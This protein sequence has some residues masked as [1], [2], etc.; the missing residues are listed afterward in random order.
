MN[1]HIYREGVWAE[2][3]ASADMLNAERLE[4]FTARKAAFRCDTAIKAN[5]CAPCITK[6]DQEQRVIRRLHL[7]PQ[8]VRNPVWGT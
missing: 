3:N 8:V 7:R 1:E 6:Q 5:R 4:N 2:R